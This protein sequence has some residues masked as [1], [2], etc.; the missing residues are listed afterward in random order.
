MPFLIGYCAGFILTYSRDKLPLNMVPIELT[1][2]AFAALERTT[3]GE[4]CKP[5]KKAGFTSAGCTTL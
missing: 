2:S 1:D 4:S 5:Y 3:A